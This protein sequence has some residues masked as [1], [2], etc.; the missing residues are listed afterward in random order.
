MGWDGSPVRCVKYYRLPFYSPLLRDCVF[1]LFFFFLV[2]R[3]GADGP[4][5]EHFLIV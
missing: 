5:M 1:V 4:Q 3:C 2:L